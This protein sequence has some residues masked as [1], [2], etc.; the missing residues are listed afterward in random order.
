VELRQQLN[1]ETFRLGKLLDPVEVAKKEIESK[2]A[3]KKYYKTYF[4]VFLFHVVAFGALGFAG[5]GPQFFYYA[6][7]NAGACIWLRWKEKKLKQQELDQATELDKR[8]PQ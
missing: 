7:L 3:L 2:K 5:F 4:Y 8:Y 1:W 6:A